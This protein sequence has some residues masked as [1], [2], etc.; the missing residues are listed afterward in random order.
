[1]KHLV[2][3]ITKK[4]AKHNG[5]TYKIYSW[6]WKVLMNG[7][8]HILGEEESLQASCK[9]QKK[10]VLI[11]LPTL[12]KKKPLETVYFPNNTFLEINMYFQ[13]IE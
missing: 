12:K 5:N 6:T 13:I 10:K 8:N 4:C 7:N 2:I 3:T 1:M 9:E 11:F